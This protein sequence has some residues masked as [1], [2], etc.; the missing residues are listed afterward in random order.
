VSEIDEDKEKRFR[1]RM[2]YE[3]EQAARA[4]QPEDSDMS[5]MD[6][7]RGA[8]QSFNKGTAF[9]F[10]DEL[11]GGGRAILDNIFPGPGAEYAEGPDMA[12]NPGNDYQ[13][14]RD[15]ERDVTKEFEEDYTKSALGLNVLGAIGS[16]GNL[17]APIKAG[18]ALPAAK[19][20]AGRS[21]V[22]GGAVGLGESE[23]DNIVD[24]AYDTGKGA[25]TALAVSS[26]LRGLGKVGNQFVKNRV[27]EDL[28]DA[29]GNRKPLH[30][31]DSG[32]GDFY[33]SIGRMPGA[34]GKLRDQEV[35]FVKEAAEKVFKESE[36]LRLAKAAARGTQESAKDA[37]TLR[38][39]DIADTIERQAVEATAAA[40]SLPK[41]AALKEARKFRESAAKASLP[42][43]AQSRLDDLNIG[44]DIND[45]RGV[46]S[47]YWNK[48]AFQEVKRQQFPW[49]N[50]GDRGLR[51]SLRTKIAE[52][53]DLALALDNALGSISKSTKKLKAAGA[54]AKPRSTQELMD[55]MD[56]NIVGIDGDA[57]MA[58]RNSFAT[59]ANGTSK[60]GW[61][62]REVANE[63][64]SF[65]R[66]N[67]DEINPELTS[68]F[69]ENLSKYTTALSY[70][71]AASGKKARQAA[72]KFTP[73]D[74]MSA[75]GKYGGK[76]M[77]ARTP[78]LES[79]ARNAGEK[80]DFTESLGKV[81]EREARDTQRLGLKA[82]RR[83]LAKEKTDLGR[84][85]RAENESISQ[86]EKSGPL[87]QA[88]AEA[89]ALNEKLMPGRTSPLSDYLM[90]REAGNFV[91]APS[92]MKPIRAAQGIGIGKM[93]GSNTTQDLLA[94]Q[95][96]KQ[97]AIAKALR[98]GDMDKYTQ[99]IARMAAMGAVRDY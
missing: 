43:S 92:G 44:D 10:G 74:W 8:V 88:R 96:S 60:N 82:A 37:F 63:F 31:T 91:P 84:S 33:G 76:G 65:I 11:V 52:D 79:S 75:S 13:M 86:L 62:L 61:A 48:D 64:D 90:A 99:L 18:S 87:V 68:Q 16:P 73:S 36:G 49:A 46:L 27:A 7:V 22:E 93:I 15:D 17:L 83:K 51:Q 45:V 72:G 20:V 19:A 56:S 14:Y 53:P 77:S 24:A 34:K 1:F 59:G 70:M 21:L 78:P 81:A 23:A 55:M 41:Q 47:N 39:Q 30:L 29:A 9:G 6:K 66:K 58:I 71:D 40:K 85:Q 80:I 42:K 5:T 25:A 98:E 97:R 95:S 54:G 2:R 69:N 12:Q 89:R 35:P 67:L 3:A 28:V 4:Q 50:R 26:T 32:V 38:S 94:G 57:L